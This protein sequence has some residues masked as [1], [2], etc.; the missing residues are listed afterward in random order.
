MTRALQ[1]TLLVLLAF[2]AIGALAG[3]ASLVLAPDGS[4]LGMTLDMIARSPFTSYRTPGALL[5]TLGLMHAV[6]FVAVL[7]RAASGW[8]LTASSGAALIIWIA[9]QMTMVDFFWLQPTFLVV[10]AIELVGA[11][12][13][14]RWPPGRQ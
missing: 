2:V 4:G 3:G 1:L 10:G 13:S 8:L 9:V 11:F 6:A 7:R 14:R 5:A 12:A